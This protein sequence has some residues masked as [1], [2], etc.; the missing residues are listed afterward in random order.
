MNL[1]ITKETITPKKAMEWLKRNVNNRPLR[2]KHC[3]R[4]SEAMKAKEWQLNGETIKFNGNGDLIDGQ[5]RLKAIVIAGT[6]IE[7]YIVRKL[8]HEAFDTIDTG[9]P[10]AVGDTFARMGEK[11][12]SHLATA[13]RNAY[14]FSEQRSTWGGSAPMPRNSEAVAYLAKN[15][16]IRLSVEFVAQAGAGAL[17]SVGMAAAL[18]YLMGCKNRKKADE[19]WTGVLGGEGLRKGM[20]AYELR[21]R[22]ISHRTTSV[23]LTR[24]EVPALS[25]KAW[26][27]FID[28]TEVKALRMTDGEDF[29]A[30]KG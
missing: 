21:R 8:P 22:L 15:P 26:N 10:R 23:K 1:N 16:G 2:E 29:P 18:H 28:G 9:A 25:I 27:A 3:N 19:F 6:P 13:I 4:L 11:Y 14:H 12:Y 17:M 20:P 7:S 30:I 24:A 5:H